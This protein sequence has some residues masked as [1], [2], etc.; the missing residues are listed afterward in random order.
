[1]QKLWSIVTKPNRLDE[2]ASG[3]DRNRKKFWNDTKKQIHLLHILGLSYMLFITGV[4]CFTTT[5]LALPFI[6]GDSGSKIF[7]LQLLMYYLCGSGL[8][9]FICVII[10]A[11]KSHF[12]PGFTGELPST[13]M[14]GMG[15]SDWSSQDDSLTGNTDQSFYWQKCSHCEIRIPPRARHCAICKTCILKRDHHCFFT[16]CCIG[17][18]NQRFFIAMAF[19]G[20]TAGFWGAFNFATYLNAN[21]TEFFSFGFYRYFLPYCFI[22]VTFGYINLSEFFLVFLFYIQITSSAGAAYY[23]WWQMFITYR[24]QTSVE[25]LK[26][27]KQYDKGPAQNFQ[28]TLGRTSFFGVIFPVPFVLLDGNGL[29]WDLNRKAA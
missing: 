1:M 4:V 29:S 5:H 9:N 22:A 17:F 19:F 7:V 3:D 15:R 23:F 11:K 8:I 10:Y 18:Y 21:Y 14:K 25:A 20:M 16:A 12:S 27:T 2:Y 6:Y 28:S 24:G 26:G 13:S